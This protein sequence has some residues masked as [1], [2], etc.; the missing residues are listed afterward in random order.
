VPHSDPIWEL[1]LAWE[2]ARVT[3]Q[4]VSP[5]ELCRDCP[6]RLTDLR[7]RVAAL[8]AVRTLAAVGHPTAAADGDRTVTYVDSRNGSEDARRLPAA[9]PGY[10]IVG[11]LGR[12][13]MGAVYQARQL[14]LNRLVALKVLLAGAAAGD[15]QRARFAAEARVVAEFRHPNIVPVFETGE[16][17]GTPFLSMELVPGGTLS[18]RLATGPLAPEAAARLLVQVADAVHH[19]HERGIIHRDLKPG[20]VLL[21]EDGVPKVSDFGL[22]KRLESA[23]ALTRTDAVLGTPSYMAPEQAEGK[24]EVG[25][26]ADVYALGAVLYHTLTGRPPFQAASALDTIRQ[27]VDLDPVPVR[28]LQP[29]VP[30]DLAVICE[31]CLRKEPERRY[32]SAGELSADLRR[33]LANEPIRARPVGPLERGWKWAGRNRAVAVSGLAV[34]VALTLG[35]TISGIYAARATAAANREASARAELETTKRNT[36]RFFDHLVKELRVFPSVGGRLSQSFLA[37]NQDLTESD[38]REFFTAPRMPD[39][40]VSPPEAGTLAQVTFN[41]TMYGD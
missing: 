40:N 41:P 8:L 31:M 9:I 13:G 11:E 7:D 12:G 2:G 25:R 35:T 14:G 10:E 26:A 29:A 28:D 23:D 1:V 24:K 19:A 17:D 18:Q 27:V 38:F 20:N 39:A 15:E 34:A 6:E 32:P 33:F 36:L 3:G 37:A 4:P 30:R 22:A 16:F 21:T 5:E